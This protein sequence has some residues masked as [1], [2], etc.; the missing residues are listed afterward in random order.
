MSSSELALISYAFNKFNLTYW[1]AALT[2]YILLEKN[3]RLSKNL[4]NNAYEPISN[5]PDFKKVNNKL[6][7]LYDT[8]H[9]KSPSF[10]SPKWANFLE[11]AWRN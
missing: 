4:S 10:M 3:D 5:I 7:K 1:A 9:I 2:D 8:A 6:Y 11:N